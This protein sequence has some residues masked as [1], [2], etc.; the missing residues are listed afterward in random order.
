[1]PAQIDPRTGLKFFDLSH[2]WG[3]QNPNWPYFEDVKIERV[4]YHAKSRVLSQRVTTVMHSGTHV[5]APAHVLEGTPFL[6]ELPLFTFFG[7]GVVVS[8]PKRKWEVVTAEDLE[9]ATPRIEPGDIAIVNTGWHKHYG[10]NVA[11]YAYS[12]GF[13]KDA[14][15]WFVKRGVKAIGTDTQALDHPLGTAIAPHGPGAPDGLLPWAVAEYEAEKE[16]KVL[17]DFPLWEP[18]HRAI[19]SHNIVGFENIGGDIDEVTGKR[20]TIAAFPWRWVGG[21]GCIVRLV[22]IVDPNG[23]FRI[24]Q[25]GNQ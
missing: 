3:L 14:G 18:C 19:M 2:P 22:A 12:P 16:R 9:K 6:H 11:Y 15:D 21:D 7:R 8:I 24:E 10:D 1:M 4:H 20:V 13:Y 23:T 17:D 25:G 5:D